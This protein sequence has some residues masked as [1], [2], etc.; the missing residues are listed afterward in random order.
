MLLHRSDLF[1]A[2]LPRPLCTN[3]SGRRRRLCLLAL[4]PSHS[5]LPRHRAVQESRQLHC[6]SAGPIALHRLLHERHQIAFSRYGGALSAWKKKR[7]ACR[8]TTER[9][10][11]SLHKWILMSAKSRVRMCIHSLKK[12]CRGIFTHTSHLP[13]SIPLCSPV[14]LVCAHFSLTKTQQH[15]GT[16]TQYPLPTVH[17]DAHSHT[18]HFAPCQCLCSPAYK[19]SEA[20]GLSSLTYFSLSP[21]P[22]SLAIP[23]TLP[24]SMDVLLESIP[25]AGA[26]NKCRI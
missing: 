25:A 7:E 24:G 1:P 22:L 12:T 15:T 18:V 16:F 11:K 26:T 21:S 13:T 5:L 8:K 2:C 14:L 17:N 3:S 19:W 10:S 4:V 9:S 23:K 6:H 20:A